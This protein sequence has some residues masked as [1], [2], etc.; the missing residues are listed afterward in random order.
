MLAVPPIHPASFKTPYMKRD[1]LLEVGLPGWGWAGVRACAG[2]RGAAGGDVGWGG[3]MGERRSSAL[4]HTVGG[5]GARWVKVA[6]QADL[7][8]TM[9]VGVGEPSRPQA[10]ALRVV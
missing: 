3:V 9:G 5:S 4:L 6:G 2:R 10:R 1:D 7:T 8:F